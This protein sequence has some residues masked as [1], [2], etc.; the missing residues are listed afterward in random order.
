MN[1]GVKLT[2]SETQEIYTMSNWYSMNSFP[3]V[4]DFH[5]E[6]FK[7]SDTIPVIFGGDFN[8]V[9]PS[10]GGENPASVKLLGNGFTDAYRSLHPDLKKYPAFTHVEGVRID[11]IYSSRY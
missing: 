9:P 2:I 3:L 1:V 6:R 7:H 8:A 4:Y 5:K 10:D 11:Q